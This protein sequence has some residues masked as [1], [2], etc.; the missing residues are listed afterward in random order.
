MKQVA[1]KKI[2]LVHE[3]KDNNANL[4]SVP[5]D[6]S[7]QIR[8]VSNCK[9]EDKDG[10]GEQ[11][12]D[13]RGCDKEGSKEGQVNYDCDDN[14]LSINPGFAEICD[15]KD[16]D[17]NNKIDDNPTGGGKNSN[18]KGVCYGD[19]K[20]DTLEGKKDWYDSYLV[21]DLNI[22]FNNL[23]QS[24]LYEKDKE[25][26]CDYYD[27]NCDG[28]VDEDTTGCPAGGTGTPKGLLPPGNAFVDYDTATGYLKDKQSINVLDIGIVSVLE[29]VIKNENL[30]GSEQ[31]P[32]QSYAYGFMV[33]VCDDGTYYVSNQKSLNPG[34]TGTFTKGHYTISKKS[35]VNGAYEESKI[36]KG[37]DNQPIKC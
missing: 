1:L 35:V 29:D 3:E 30:G 32:L 34:K 33:F 18:L 8:I 23:Q 36:L 13:L 2:R 10:Y 4:F 31:K 17:C 16:N 21:A 24:T 27:N 37:L 14:D 15:G 6:I 26:K 7:A 11:G 12:T 9:D 20:C 22:K 19:K 28:I 5:V 25:T